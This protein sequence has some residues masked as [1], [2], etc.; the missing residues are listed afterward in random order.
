MYS[1][2]VARFVGEDGIVVAI[3]P[4]P[5]SFRALL[6]GVELNGL[7]N[8]LALNVALDDREGKAT[9]CQKFITAISSI[10]ELNECR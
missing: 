10:I 4:D 5:V 8:V 6:M 7:R 9:L 1:F 2:P 3:E